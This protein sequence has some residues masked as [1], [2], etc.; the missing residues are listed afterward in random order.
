MNKSDI[1]MGGLLSIFLGLF[2]IIVAFYFAPQVELIF[3]NPNGYE[4]LQKSAMWYL[5]FGEMFSFVGFALLW[6]GRDKS[7]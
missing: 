5:G 6:T 4:R 2:F 3:D 7:Y 1:R